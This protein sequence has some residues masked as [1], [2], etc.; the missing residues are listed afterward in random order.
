MAEES[1]AA[2][3]SNLATPPWRLTIATLPGLPWQVRN[4]LAA[5]RYALVLADLAELPDDEIRDTPGVGP[6][7]LAA[8]KAAVAAR[9]RRTENDG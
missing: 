3:I 5:Q 8:L 1:L 9:P 4:A 6:E 7:E 2:M